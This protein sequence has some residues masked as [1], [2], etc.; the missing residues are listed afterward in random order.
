VH[1]KVVQDLLGHESVLM[2]LDIY[3]HG[4]PALA[5]Q[6]VHGLAEVLLPSP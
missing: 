6:A 3:S 1:A 5:E 2:T 4:I